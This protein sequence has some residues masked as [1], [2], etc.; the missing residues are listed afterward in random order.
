LD[1]NLAA[2]TNDDDGAWV[3]GGAGHACGP[4]SCLQHE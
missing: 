4:P 1:T 2:G 3:K